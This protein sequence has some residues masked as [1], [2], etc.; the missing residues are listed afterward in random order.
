VDY[1][2]GENETS[3]TLVS[4]P[5]LVHLDRAKQESGVDLKRENLPDFVYTGIW[6]YARFPEHYSGDGSAATKE[7]GEWN[8]NGW[9]DSIDEALRA[10]KADEISLKLQNEFY[11]KSRHPLETKQ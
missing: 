6:W 11:E 3:N 8:M 4:H 9:I 1:H 5:E 2:A 10:I 7:L